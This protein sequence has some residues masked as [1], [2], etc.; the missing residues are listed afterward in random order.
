V[1][2]KLKDAYLMPFLKNKSIEDEVFLT[3]AAIDP[4]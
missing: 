4:G 1:A 2:A 3:P